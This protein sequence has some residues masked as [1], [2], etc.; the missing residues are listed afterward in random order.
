MR[1]RI[2]LSLILS[3]FISS[4][5]L[6]E[7]EIS[8]VSFVQDGEISKL[9]ISTS[10][11]VVAEKF[12]V[13]DNKQILLDFKGVKAENRTLRAID[14]SEFS[15]STVYI[16]AFRK[17]QV[18][19]EIRFVVQLRD[20]VQSRLSLLENK[21][22]LDIEN[23]FGVF[24]DNSDST[25]DEKTE[26]SRGLNIPKSNSVQD[27]LDNLTL[28]GNKKYVGRRIT[29][30]VKNLPITELLNMIADTSG[31]N[32]IIDADVTQRPNMTISLTN[33][34]WDEALDTILKLNKLVGAKHANILQIKTEE[35]D[36][37]EK[38]A[39][40]KAEEKRKKADPLVTK[41]FPLSFA[42]ITEIIPV[43]SKY[44][45]NNGETLSDARTNNLIIKDTVE[46]IEKMR[47]IIELLDTPT[48]QVLIEAKIVEV[49]ESNLFNLGFSNETGGLQLDYNESGATAT[50]SS[51][52]LNPASGSM[53]GT[54][55]VLDDKFNLNFLL[56]LQETE[57]NLKIISSPR[58]VTQNNQAAT[59]NTTETRNRE[60]GSIPD[61]G[62]GPPLPNIVTLNASLSLEVTPQ[63][64]ND[65]S[66]GLEI[67]IQ[68]DDFGAVDEDIIANSLNTNVLVDNGST[69]VIG[70]LYKTRNSEEERGIPWLRKIPL[71]GWL[72]KSG[73][74]TEETR[75]ELVVF[76]TPRI[77][78]A[79]ENIQASI[80]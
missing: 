41:V 61:P 32:I 45:S 25:L 69:V 13:I 34:P 76:I 7:V 1:F 4:F 20:N 48:P 39:A 70:G 10:G 74:N 2:V 22:I 80:E 71:L 19:G 47:K 72:F 42:K 43:L 21:V 58:V 79:G 46:N 15:G 67:K 14:T 55:A 12:H 54:L 60:L 49:E 5:A 31:F 57:Q 78:K 65:G 11:Q 73:L 63:I 59:I 26:N 64:S 28:A 62:G 38:E 29:I 50:S 23:R 44:K 53:S 40:V 35:K 9:I 24:A 52:T 56:N 30:N 3:I 75:R 33:T 51:F 77:I 37:A 18:P 27:I 36:I 16:S 68:K 66:I 6:A 17:E 8:K